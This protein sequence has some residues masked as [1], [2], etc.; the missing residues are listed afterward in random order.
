MGVTLVK[1]TEDLIY[2]LS[3]GIRASPKCTCLVGMKRFNAVLTRCVYT[4][5]WFVERMVT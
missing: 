2:P 5:G 1:V 4:F 3:P